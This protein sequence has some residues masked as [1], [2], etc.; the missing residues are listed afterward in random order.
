MPLSNMARRVRLGAVSVAGR[1]MSFLAPFVG[2]GLDSLSITSMLKFRKSSCGCR[3][4]S[5]QYC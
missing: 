4:L 2:V 1:V 3:S 5:Y